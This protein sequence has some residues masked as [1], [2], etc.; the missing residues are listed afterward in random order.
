M[1]PWACNTVMWHWSADILFWQLS[2]DHNM[3][4]FIK[5]N[6]GSRLPHLLE[7]LTF[8]IGF[9][10]ACRY[11]AVIACPKHVCTRGAKTRQFFNI[12]DFS[13]RLSKPLQKLMVLLH[14]G[15]K[16]IL[17]HSAAPPM[18]FGDDCMTSQ[19]HTALK[20]WAVCVVIQ[21]LWK[22]QSYF[23]NKLNVLSGVLR[24]LRPSKT[25]T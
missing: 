15:Y 20:V 21:E 6:T 3:D 14:P 12:S 7:S 1:W 24:K 23:Y 9:R 22:D 13:I 11:G 16:D 19:K 10:V 8:H 18:N 2:I 4:V 17:F 5:L 25:K